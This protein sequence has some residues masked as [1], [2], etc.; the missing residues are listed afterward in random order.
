MYIYIYTYVSKIN[1]EQR[2]RGKVRKRCLPEIR[3]EINAQPSC[4][5]TMISCSLV[6]NLQRRMC[7]FA[8][9]SLVESLGPHEGCLG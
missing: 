9:L 8:L 2:V 1:R 7:F 6:S 5:I 3:G 4:W